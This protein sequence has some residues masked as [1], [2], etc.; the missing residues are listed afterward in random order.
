MKEVFVPRQELRVRAWR[1]DEGASFFP[2]LAFHSVLTE[3]GE[4]SWYSWYPIILHHEGAICIT[5]LSGHSYEIQ[6][7]YHE[8]Y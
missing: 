1:K 2:V 5:E 8:D 4:E 3:D 6:E 7:V